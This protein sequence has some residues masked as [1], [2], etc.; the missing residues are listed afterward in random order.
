MYIEPHTVSL[1]TEPDAQEPNSTQSHKTLN[2]FFLN[3]K[4]KKFYLVRCQEEAKMTEELTATEK[5]KF[6]FA[7]SL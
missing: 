6:L 3:G 7:L 1:H 4:G 5:E 2:A